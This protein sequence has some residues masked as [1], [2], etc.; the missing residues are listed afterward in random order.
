MSFEICLLDT[1]L[2]GKI[3]AQ[4]KSHL[5][6]HLSSLVEALVIGRMSQY[7]IHDLIKKEVDILAT[8]ALKNLVRESVHSVL[9]E[10][11]IKER[12]NGG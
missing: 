8:Q 2:V 11:Y 10:L 6:T 3:E 12:S 5:D 1:E 4:L 9:G 7:V